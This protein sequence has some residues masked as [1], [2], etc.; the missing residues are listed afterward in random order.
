[1][2][3]LLYSLLCLASIVSFYACND[4][5]SYDVTGNPNNLFYIFN[6]KW[7]EINGEKNSYKFNITH[8]PVGFMGEVPL[9]QTPIR[10]TH[11]VS[12]TL[13]ITVR[14]DSSLVDEYNNTKNTTYAACPD[15]IVQLVKS[16]V[17][18][19]VGSYI[20]KDSI[21]ISLSKEH[22]EELTES[23]YLIPIS[24]TSEVKGTVVSS[25]HG[26]IWLVLQTNYTN[27]KN[28]TSIND[29]TG[30]TISNYNGWVVETKDGVQ[31]E[32]LIF[33]ALTADTYLLVGRG[34]MSMTIDMLKE[35]NIS[36]FMFKK[37]TIIQLSKVDIS[38]SSDKETWTSVGGGSLFTEPTGEQY[39]SFYK[40]E[41][42]RYIKFN[43]TATYDFSS[44]SLNSLRVYTTDTEEITHVA[45]VTLNKTKLAFTGIGESEALIPT[46]TPVEASDYSVTWE[47][48]NTNVATVDSDGKVTAVGPGE[49]TVTVKTVDGAKTAQCAVKVV[50]VENLFANPGFET[51]QSELENGKFKD[52]V[53]WNVYNESKEPNWGAG[54][55][56]SSIRSTH[57]QYVTEG[58]KSI[59][60]HSDAR[61]LTQKID[62]SKLKPNTTYRISY[63]YFTSSSASGNG[64]V[65]YDILLGAQEFGKEVLEMEAHTTLKTTESKQTFSKTFTTSSS[66]PA[67]VWFT[68]FR[69]GGH[70][71]GVDWLDNM[72]LKEVIE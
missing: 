44:Y 14:H 36:G 70:L 8:T 67:A 49:A 3:Q 12:S 69:A 23:E 59:I 63:D 10:S 16:S 39:I 31:N 47:S 21:E 7:S 6:Q 22:I 64:G 9:L 45:G 5:E 54:S 20:S 62:G 34:T 26:V 33:D 27:I 24:I 13:S 11:P 46:I 1:M 4:D 52:G 32:K 48:S 19:E 61:Y 41:K 71:S 37:N 38:I 42:A 60:M 2:K 56:F 28:I 58:Q 55:P 18:F 72:S 15:N 65:E 50:I 57:P 53:Y 43:L 25:K 17:T 66:V 51:T 68:L 40:S 35:K 30:F 29:M